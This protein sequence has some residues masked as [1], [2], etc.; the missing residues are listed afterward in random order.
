MESQRKLVAPTDLTDNLPYIFIPRL[1]PAYIAKLEAARASKVMANPGLK[2]Q[3][4]TWTDV[5]AVAKD[6]QYAVRIKGPEEVLGT[7]PEAAA[8]EAAQQTLPARPRQP[9]KPVFQSTY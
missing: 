5:V 6:D 9:S 7:A 4:L 2:S 1:S 8:M 3:S